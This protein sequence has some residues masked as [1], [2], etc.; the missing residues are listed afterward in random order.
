[1]F[2]ARP[3]SAKDLTAPADVGDKHGGRLI[4]LEADH[5]VIFAVGA[6][7]RA[8]TLVIRSDLPTQVRER[9][10]YVLP[11]L[12]RTRQTVLPYFLIERLPTPYSKV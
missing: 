1:M 2:F 8:G 9:P 10:F 11:A 6:H 3:F 5:Q 4:S 12:S 7:D